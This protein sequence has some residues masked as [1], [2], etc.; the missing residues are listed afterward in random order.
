METPIR[1]NT[2]HPGLA[3]ILSLFVPGLGQLYKGQIINAIVWFVI[4]LVGYFLLIIPGIVLHLLCI[5][6]ASK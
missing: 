3:A 6:G 2:F 1:Q 4:V 5:F